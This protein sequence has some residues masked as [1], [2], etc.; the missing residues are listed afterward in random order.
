[1][2]LDRPKTYAKNMVKKWSSPKKEPAQEEPKL[3]KIPSWGRFAAPRGAF[4]GVLRSSWAG[5][6]FGGDIFYHFLAH[7]FGR[8]RTICV[9]F[10]VRSAIRGQCQHK[11]LIILLQLQE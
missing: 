5:S 10:W 7:V 11:C 9:A 2:V 6:V 8:S 3:R 4:L 1:M